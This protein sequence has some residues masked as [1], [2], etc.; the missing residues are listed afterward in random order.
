M[1]VAVG[2]AFLLTPTACGAGRMMPSILIR[3]LPGLGLFLAALFVAAC[4]GAPTRPSPTAAV[5]GSVPDATSTNVAPTVTVD[6]DG[7][8]TCS[9][10]GD[11]P[12]TLTAV[13]HASDADSDTITFAWSGCASGTTARATCS[14][15]KAGDV[16][17][18][19][20]V[21]DGHGHQTSASAT[22]HGSTPATSNT[23]P[24]VNVRFDGATTCTPMPNKAC[25]LDV[26]VIASDP[27]ND[28]LEYKWDGCAKG[29]STR[30]TCSL[31][32]PGPVQAT[33][34]AS[35]GHG[36]DVTASATAVG[37]DEPPT[38]KVG[39]VSVFSSGSIEVL[40]SIVD[41]EEGELCGGGTNFC[42]SV[43][44]SGAC[45]GRAGCSR[46]LCLG[47]LE[48]Y[49]TQSAAHGT[50]TLSIEVQ[51]SFSKRGTTKYTFDLD[52]PKVRHF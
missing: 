52:D 6:F 50:C 8:S 47:G 15:A 51:D 23:A 20:Q 9:T 30:A 4:G 27:D 1:N 7:P 36:H 25:T 22:G 10:T 21:S 16:V 46:N 2:I 18:T 5:S 31:S 35:D 38:V 44:G 26:T 14:V 29:S 40:G 49:A 3:R 19:V 12:C 34:T 28:A 43:T 45:T 41:P 39:Y 33:V 11:K 32:K 17:A 24:T 13:A 42:L 37:E 48:L